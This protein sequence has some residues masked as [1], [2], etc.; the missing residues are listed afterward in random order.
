MMC[1][2]AYWHICSTSHLALSIIP[3]V[4][5]LFADLP[6]SKFIQKFVNKVKSRDLNSYSEGPYK[7]I[8]ID[9]NK[10][11]SYNLQAGQHIQLIR[12]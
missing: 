1:G 5:E 10:V 11:L 9:C 8:R 6:F 7:A 4:Q 2:G 3:Q 12:I